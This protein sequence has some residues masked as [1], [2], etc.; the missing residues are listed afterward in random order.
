M[1]EWLDK[2]R[3]GEWG[4]LQEHTE[5]LKSLFRGKISTDTA[6]KEVVQSV[7]GK[8][9]PSDAAYQFSQL[10]LNAATDFQATQEPIV[11]LLRDIHQVDSTPNEVLADFNMYLREILDSLEAERYFSEP[12]SEHKLETS[13]GSQAVTPGD[14]WVNYNGFYASLVFQ[15]GFAS[16]G[17]VFGFF[18]LR[19]LLEYNSDTHEQRRQAMIKPTPMR[20]FTGPPISKEKQL[21]YDVMAA[22]SWV[23]PALYDMQN[24]DF[25]HG[26][27]RG[28]AVPTDLWSGEPGLSKGRWQLWKECL[29][30]IAER[31]DLRES[32]R[33]AAANAAA[34]IEAFGEGSKSAAQG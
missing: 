30:R 6:A 1:D 19:D 31:D 24:T 15:A 16:I 26:W 23:S 14:R 22:V 29:K 7:N 13:A 9:K 33:E 34:A 17:A 12:E 8:T 4:A 28:I 3:E 11:A 25:G 20:P 5:I 2:Q 10:V 18:R 21:E 27:A 32:V